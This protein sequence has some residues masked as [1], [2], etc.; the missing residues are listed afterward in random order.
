MDAKKVIL[1]HKLTPG[2]IKLNNYLNREIGMPL[3][4]ACIYLLSKCKVYKDLRDSVIV[5]FPVKT[6]DILAS[7]ITYGNGEV[8]GSNILKEAFFRDL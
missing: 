6:D 1:A 3:K 7:F 4:A 2:E 8:K 5:L